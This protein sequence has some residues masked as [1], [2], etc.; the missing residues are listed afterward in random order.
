MVFNSSDSDVSSSSGRIPPALRRHGTAAL[1]VVS[2]STGDG[3]EE[4]V[5]KYPWS[6]AVRGQAV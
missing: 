6:S 2:K 4:V 1:K 3:T 5:A